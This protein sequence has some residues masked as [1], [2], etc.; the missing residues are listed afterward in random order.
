MVLF[1]SVFCLIYNR[2]V[3]PFSKKAQSDI[4]LFN[5]ISIILIGYLMVVFSDM[6]QDSD[7]KYLFGWIT[8]ILFIINFTINFV[9]LVYFILGPI[10]SKLLTKK[11]PA[12]KA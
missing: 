4:E 1:T 8:I 6:L 3:M 5:E 10:C 2:I 9:L 12:K 11:K 7:M